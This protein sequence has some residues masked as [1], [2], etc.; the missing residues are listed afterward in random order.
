MTPILAA[1]LAK[2]VLGGAAAWITGRAVAKTWAPLWQLAIYTALLAVAVGLLGAMLGGPERLSLVIWT[3]DALAL[4]AV[5]LLGHRATR[6][7][8]MPAQYPWLFE[9]S[10]PLSWR[11]KND[12]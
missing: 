11:R 10:G 12:Q 1:L 4:G 8:Q 9:R 3:R 7:A 2:A 5:A 6:A